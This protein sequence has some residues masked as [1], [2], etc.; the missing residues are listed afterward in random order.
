APHKVLKCQYDRSC[1]ELENPVHRAS[2][3]HS[4]MPDFF[5]PCRYHQNCKDKSSKHR[6]LYSHGEQ[7][8][9][10]GDASSGKSSEQ[11]SASKQKQNYQHDS[12]SMI[13]CRH[14]RQCREKNDQH[15][16]SQYSH[17]SS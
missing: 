17:P 2:Y 5:I 6:Q 7:V 12:K 15:H 16:A 11:P 1:R 14:G 8:P 13:P 9:I 10:P 4:N 3:R